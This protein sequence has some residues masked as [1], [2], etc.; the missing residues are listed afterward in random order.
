M[1]C[2][3]LIIT[4]SLFLIAAPGQAETSE[5]KGLAIAREVKKRN[6]GFNNYTANSTMILR[7]RQGRENQRDMRTSVLETAADGDKSV[8]IFDS[9]GDVRGTA[10]LTFTH[11]V[12]DDDQWLY[13][14]ALKR[15]KRITAS[16]KSGSFMG[17]EFAFE[18]LG[19]REVEKYTYQ[20]LKDEQVDDHT[21]F[22]IELMPKDR[23]SG[24]SRILSWVDTAEY[25]AHKEDYYDKHGKLLKTLHLSD[26][27][28]Y[29]GFLWRAHRLEM[30]NHQNGK[31]TDLL[32][33]GF[34]FD[35]GLTDRDFTTTSLK[36]SR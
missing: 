7:N 12:G 17:S 34:Q 21:C 28:Q 19:S 31:D 24:Y 16:N 20:Y 13:L 25:I 23:D 10:L 1:K 8:T 29:L 9:P 27:Q 26:Y 30:V 11:K 33:S 32:L 18:D 3:L 36:R 15:V 35:T 2:I 22:L 14:P 4:T 5:Q 6:S